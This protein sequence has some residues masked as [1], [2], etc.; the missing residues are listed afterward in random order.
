[1]PNPLLTPKH[2]PGRSVAVGED[3]GKC[4]AYAST[5]RI[6]SVGRPARLVACECDVPCN[7]ENGKGDVGEVTRILGE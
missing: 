4:N 2:D 7:G 3:D 1:M 6:I 5:V